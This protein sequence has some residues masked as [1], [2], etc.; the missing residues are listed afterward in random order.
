M[1]AASTRQRLSPT[2]QIDVMYLVGG[3]TQCQLLCQGPADAAGQPVVVGPAEATALDIVLVPAWRHGGAIPDSL[4][5]AKAIV[6]A[7]R[8][9]GR[10]Q[11]R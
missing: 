11:S 7:S 9:L 4:E 6:G 8:E 2:A 10:Y 5:A 1:Y 3:G